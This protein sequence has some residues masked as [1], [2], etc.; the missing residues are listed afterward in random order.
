[1]LGKAPRSVAGW[2]AIYT[3]CIICTEDFEKG[4]DI[5]V[6]PCNH[7]F[8]PACVDPWLLGVSGTCPLCRIDLRPKDERTSESVERETDEFGNPVL[9]EGQPDLE[10]APPLR[11]DGNGNPERISFRQNLMLNLTGI[12][13][14]DRTT[15]EE[16]VLALR[17]LRGQ[18]LA[19]QRR[20]WGEGLLGFCGFYLPVWN[21]RSWSEE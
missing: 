10:L 20:A 11:G 13:R 15:R 1:M 9:R 8:H 3:R 2:G 19:R 14:P 6:L 17:Q 5:R 4:E 7:T 12:G 16:R 21:S 18:E